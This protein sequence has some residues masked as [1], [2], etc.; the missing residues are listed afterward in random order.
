MSSIDNIWDCEYFNRCLN[1]HKCLMCGQEQRLLKLPEDKQRTKRRGRTK[2]TSI[3][4]IT[5]N[6]GRTLEEY[7]KDRFN[8][9]P[10]VKEWQARRQLGSG[11]IWFMP[12]D[13][14]DTVVLAEC[15]E[16][17]TINSKGEKNITIPKTMLEKIEKEAKTY[18]TFPALVFRY[19]GD[20]SG[21]TYFVQDFEVLCEMVHEIKFLRHENQVVTNERNMYKQVS[22]ELYKELQQLKRKYGEE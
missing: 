20:E 11:N 1:N 21:K 5:D 8:S 22:E 16:R 18:N 9:L 7:V 15:K 6:S 4:S 17:S 12:G 19:K 14:A 2:S 10:T 3:T 13:V